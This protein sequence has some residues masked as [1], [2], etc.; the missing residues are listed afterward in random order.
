MTIER[1]LS[2]RFSVV[3]RKLNHVKKV[4]DTLV[5]NCMLLLE[6]LEYDRSELVNSQLDLVATEITEEAYVLM[7]GK[8]SILDDFVAWISQQIG[9]ITSS[10][11]NALNTF[12]HWILD[13][14]KVPFTA[15]KTNLDRVWSSLYSNFQTR[16]TT[17]G[18]LLGKVAENISH[19]I[20]NFVTAVQN[21]LSHAVSDM[22]NWSSGLI[23]NANDFLSPLGQAL[24]VG[25]NAMIKAM[26]TYLTID[27]G[28]LMKLQKD[29]A[30]A[31]A[32]A[33][34]ENIKA[35]IGEK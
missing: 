5:E 27:V 22:R 9:N 11:Q 13:G 31:S 8:H 26:A 21:D 24:S 23:E 34:L 12:Y 6:G 2:A 14:I 28:D 30:K 33:Q 10:A 4:A 7:G 1:I 19:G 16:A 32:D 20:G 35:R 29:L 15:L 18:N 17:V 3:N 25:F